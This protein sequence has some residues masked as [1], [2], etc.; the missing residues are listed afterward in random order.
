MV[1]PAGPHQPV[2]QAQRRRPL[3]QRGVDLRQPVRRHQA[4][5][6]R[7]RAE[8]RLRRPD[9]DRPAGLHGADAGR[10]QRRG[11]RRDVHLRS[12]DPD[13]HDPLR[14]PP[15]LAAA[16][17]GDVQ[18]GSGAD[19]GRRR[20]RRRP[21]RFR[22]DR[23]LLDVTEDEALP[24][25]RVTLRPGRCR[26]RRGGGGVGAGKAAGTDRFVPLRRARHAPGDPPGARVPR[27]GDARRAR[28]THHVP[29]RRSEPREPL[30][31]PAP[32]RAGSVPA[33]RRRRAAIS[34]APPAGRRPTVTRRRRRSDRPV[35]H[36]PAPDRARDERRRPDDLHDLR[37]GHLGGGHR[38]GR[39]LLASPPFDRA[40]APPGGRDDLHRV[41]TDRRRPRHVLLP[42]GE[43]VGRH[44]GLRTSGPHVHVSGLQLVRRR[45]G[46]PR[47]ASAAGGE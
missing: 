14:P 37:H 35:E 5:R 39:S 41:R 2:R 12:P 24:R 36:F 17:L 20:R 7:G 42:P 23:S 9:V 34:P 43:P 46:D 29:R 3:L 28:A 8:D 19:Q 10:P 40:V 13:P 45:S 22:D 47:L 6:A 33:A 4:D 21:A 27:T 38:P 32:L 18:H 15:G 30:R 44:R 16:L 26:R 11:R 31:R 1:V 25:R